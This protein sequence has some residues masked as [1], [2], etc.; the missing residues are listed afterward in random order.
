MACAKVLPW[1][2]L[3][4][5]HMGAALG[6][7][8]AGPDLPDGTGKPVVQRMCAPCHGLSVVVSTRRSQEEW[9]SVVANMVSRGAVGSA[10]D[11]KQ[12]VDYL[13]TH[14][15]AA[16]PKTEPV[17]P[18]SSSRVLKIKP[19]ALKEQVA[20]HT[21]WSVSGHDAGA[22]RYSPLSQITP[23]N[24]TSLKVA[25]KFETGERGLPFEVSPIVVDN[26]MYLMT[27]TQHV[28]AL[29]PETG[30][31]LWNFDAH[32]GKGSVGRGISY[33][34]GNSTTGPRIVFGTDKAQLVASGCKNGPAGE[35]LRR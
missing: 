3:A 14:F 21:D 8:Q 13:S 26:V 20:G 12:A 27:P 19:S 1:I 22:T 32:Q 35:G 16:Q 11:R 34:P 10:E 7:A 33:W 17:K 23:E 4:A 29:E 9:Q 5:F 28:A 2:S 18:V 30:R 6:F 15:G 31:E 24:V 25:W